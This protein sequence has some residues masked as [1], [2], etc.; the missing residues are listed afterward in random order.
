MKIWCTHCVDYEEQELIY[1][2][3]E[4]WVTYCPTHKEYT[5]HTVIFDGPPP[6]E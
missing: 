4:F 5:A 3:E 6:E 2:Q 1:E